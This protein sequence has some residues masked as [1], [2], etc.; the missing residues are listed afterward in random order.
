MFTRK[1]LKENAKQQLKG[2]W[3][4]AI[5]AYFIAAAIVSVLSLLVIF[6][7]LKK[8]VVGYQV[9]FPIWTWILFVVIFLA[10]SGLVI[11]I[12]KFFLDLS[13]R[14][15][16]EVK[17]IFDGYKIF[18]K[19]LLLQLLTFIFTYLWSLLLVI[20]GIVASYRY[21]L[22]AY[23]LIDDETMTAKQAI[24]QSK[25]MMMGHKGDLFV[26]DLSF[27]GWAI[28]ATIPF[29]LGYLWLC[30]YMETTYAN[31]YLS[32]KQSQQENTAHICD[33][34]K[35]SS[36]TIYKRQFRFFV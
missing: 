15:G 1:E 31:F 19:S 26:L 5:L 27:I 7:T 20:P 10:S 33:G 34:E 6:P 4:R 16:A 32:L 25:Q 17:T 35:V 9:S 2:N 8:S 28:L 29:G 3:G 13:R 14:S 36:G 18:G 12:A 11:G 30:P 23:L 21:R 24:D 22:A